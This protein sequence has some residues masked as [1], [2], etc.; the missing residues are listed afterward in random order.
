M[1]KVIKEDELYHHGIKGQKWGVRRFQNPDGT[2]TSAGRKR[3]MEANPNDSAVTKR[4]KADWNNLSDKEFRKKYQTT[5]KVYEKRVNK[6]G[7]PYMKSPL[8]KAGKKLSGVNKQEK[9]QGKKFET[10]EE[11]EAADRN[12]LKKALVIGA[13]V[14][15][16]AIAAYG[17]YKVAQVMKDKGTISAAKDFIKG[18]KNNS[19]ADW[20]LSEKVVDISNMGKP[21][22][23]PST[24]QDVERELYSK[25]A[26]HLNERPF[27]GSKSRGLMG[28]DYDAQKELVKRN[29]LP[30]GKMVSNG[31]NFDPVRDRDLIDTIYS[32][33]KDAETQA[34][35]GKKEALNALDT[36]DRIRKKKME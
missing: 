33:R 21:R 36:L 30:F 35:F 18:F 27:P 17:G 4:V 31:A 32:V 5:K 26:T 6:Y 13:S 2:L 19:V 34:I 16:G 9:K 8:A 7:D 29:G 14:A 1:W 23:R 11:V 24:A 3:Y 25:A 22:N 20:K 15:A 28:L 10:A 12:G